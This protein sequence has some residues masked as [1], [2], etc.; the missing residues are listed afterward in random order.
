MSE[1]RPRIITIARQLGSGGGELGQRL[2]ERLGFTYIDRQILTLAAEALGIE[3]RQLSARS[4]RVQDFWSR[5]LRPFSF[6]A[7]AAVYTPPPFQM[8]S[9][10]EVIAAEREV[11]VNLASRGDCV[12]VGHAG[13]GLLC[14]WGRVL[15]V[16][17]HAPKAFRV[18]RL[19]RYYGAADEAEAERLIADADRDRER[20][21]RE[22]CGRAWL[23]VR[24]Y[25]V[26]FDVACVGLDAAVEF[27]ATLALRD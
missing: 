12:V 22:A 14:D 21:V 8:P 13:F 23:D 7:G 17:V 10:D 27:V 19:M 24:N 16:F 6:G 4:E 5:L 11:L 2:S 25:H 18:Q 26:S 9:D 3:E 15:S 20:Y 1:D